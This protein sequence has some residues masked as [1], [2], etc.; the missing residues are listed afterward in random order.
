MCG[1]QYI[2][3]PA[4]SLADSLRFAALTGIPIALD[5]TLDEACTQIHSAAGGAKLGE[6]EEALPAVSAAGGVAAVVLKPAVLG[7]FERTARVAAWARVRGMQVRELAV[8]TMT[9]HVC[10]IPC[11]MLSIHVRC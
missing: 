6:L 9:A 4:A 5:E 10:T 1:P 2:E 11:D 3:E 8:L 7:G